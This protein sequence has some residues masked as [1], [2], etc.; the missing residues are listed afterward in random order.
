MKM[1]DNK[2]VMVED[3]GVYYDGHLNRPHNDAKI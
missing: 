2:E 1:K 3:N